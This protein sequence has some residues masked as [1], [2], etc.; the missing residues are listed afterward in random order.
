MLQPLRRRTWAPRGQTPIH[1]CWDRHD[2][3][4]AIGAV[5]L[6]PRLRRFGLYFQLYDHNIRT[7]DVVAFLRQLRRQLRRRV[8]LVWD[9]W[10]VHRSAEKQLR[11]EGAEWLDVEWLPAYAPDLNPVEAVWSYTKHGELANFLPDDVDDL[12][13]GVR[14][15]LLDQYHDQ[16]LKESYFLTARLNL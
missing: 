1:R 3:V 12:R 4:S 6:A 10:K 14:E 15:S 5:T 2:R 7:P 13:H 8:I 9:R 11:R 16:A